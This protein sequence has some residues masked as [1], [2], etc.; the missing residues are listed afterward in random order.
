M[1]LALTT[2]AAASAA[3]T[4]SSGRVTG[5]IGVFGLADSQTYGEVIT[6]PVTGKLTSFTLYLN[7]GVGE[8]TGNVG[9][10][11]G[12][13]TF[14]YGY[15][16]P[17][18]LY[19]STAVPSTRA[20]AYTFSPDVS[21]TAGDQY[22]LFLSVYGVAGADSST[23]MPSALTAPYVDYFVWNNTSNPYG[24]PI[25]PYDNPSWNYFSSYNAK[26]TATFNGGMPPWN[27]GVPEPATWALMLVGLGGLGSALRSRRRAVAAK[28]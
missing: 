1:A 25:S 5:A 24:N 17:S 14:G 27:S 13:A 4:I 8:L 23:S 15:G 7:G 18:T 12:A 6:S 21:V 10:W 26:V 9:T 2:N 11:N 28:A 3:V 19:T 22:V 20:Q 16:S